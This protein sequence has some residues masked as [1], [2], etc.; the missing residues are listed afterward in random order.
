MSFVNI[1]DHRIAS[2]NVSFNCS[3]FIIEWPQAIRSFSR[4]RHPN[5]TWKYG[6]D[7]ALQETELADPYVLETH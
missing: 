7:T 2:F 1:N 5:A 6:T 3:R 4:C